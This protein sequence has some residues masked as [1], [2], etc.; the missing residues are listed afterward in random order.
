MSIPLSLLCFLALLGGWIIIP[1][2]QVFPPAIFEHPSH[3]I[4]YISIAVPIIG[5][6][7]AYLVFLGKQLNLRFFLDIAFIQKL[8]RFWFSGW[9]IDWLYDQI[10]VKPYYNI[11]KS[12]KQEPVDNFYGF[13]VNVSQALNRW[14]SSGQSG[15]MRRYIT[16][17]VFG[18]IVVL[19]ILAGTL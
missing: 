18:L 11:A 2:N 7:I 8:Q 12:L 4:E 1:V 13:I 10:L 5:V 6:I 3:W 16:S 14:L 9:G 19:I 17:M 15:Q